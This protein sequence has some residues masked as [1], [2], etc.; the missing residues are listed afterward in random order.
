[1]WGPTQRADQGPGTIIINTAQHCSA[2]RHLDHRASKTMALH[3]V[4]D[5]AYAD[6][7]NSETGIKRPPTPQWSVQLHCSQ[8]A[9]C[10]VPQRGE[11]P[12]TLTHTYKNTH[13]HHT[14]YP[15]RSHSHSDTPQGTKSS[16]HCNAAKGRPTWSHPKRNRACFC[17]D[18]DWLNMQAS[19]CPRHSSPPNF[20]M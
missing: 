1:M 14:Q 13:R 7:V 16:A 2:F 9:G 4:V 10:F 6:A 20:A 19:T 18:S 3:A 8:H 17:P 5:A 15:K 12:H 11:T